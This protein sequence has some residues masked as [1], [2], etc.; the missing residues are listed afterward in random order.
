MTL[1]NDWSVEYLNGSTWTEIPNVQSVSCFVGRT[2]AVDEWGPS[3]ATVTV[4]YP[5]GWNSPLANLASGTK[6]RLFA[7]GRTAA[8]P[9]WTGLVADATLEVGQIWNSSTSTGNADFLTISCEGYIAAAGRFD[10]TIQLSG[11]YFTTPSAIPIGELIN[12]LSGASFGPSRPRFVM[13]YDSSSSEITSSV[14]ISPMTSS[15]HIWKFDPLEQLQAFCFFGRFRLVDG[16]RKSWASGAGATNDPAMYVGRAPHETLTTTVGF[17]DVANNATNRIF[18]QVTFDGLADQYYNAANITYNTDRTNPGAVSTVDADINL[19]P[20]RTITGTFPTWHAGAISPQPNY[21]TVAA[22]YANVYNPS[23]IAISTISATT[24]GQQTQNLDTLGIANLELGYL[25][26]YVVPVTLRG[27]TFYC[28]IEGVQVTADT[29]SARFTYYVTPT[30]T[31][32]WFTL[33]S[34]AFGV[35]D[36]NRLGIY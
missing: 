25:P 4:W 3:R 18:D 28:Q 33:D 23:A 14:D 32:A 8:N 19:E 15:A 13:S 17:S 35:L 36:Q 21:D 9:S 30:G 6:I 1:Y 34:A 27:Q 12:V 11:S 29:T 26:L 16:V 2:N 5:N 31:T 10:G 22:Y 24:S 20:I 7:P